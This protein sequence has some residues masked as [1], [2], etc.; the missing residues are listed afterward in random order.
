MNAANAANAIA[1]R[2]G[3]LGCCRVGPLGA[4]GTLAALLLRCAP[5][6]PLRFAV[7]L[8]ARTCLPGD[9]RVS[10]ARKWTRLGGRALYVLSV[11]CSTASSSF[12]SSSGI[13]GRLFASAA[14]GW[15]CSRSFSDSACRSR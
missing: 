1:Y 6:T 9:A 4:V 5:A 8:H 11:R 13:S 3:V 10:C 15:S 12:V 14:S 7:L 2:A